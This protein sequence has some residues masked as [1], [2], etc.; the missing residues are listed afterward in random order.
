MKIEIRKIEKEISFLDQ[1]M[2]KLHMN[3]LKIM[4]VRKKK[5]QDLRTLRTNF[6]SPDEDKDFQISLAKLLKEPT[7]Q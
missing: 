1:E 2:E 7:T 5:D 4:T 6:E 3:L